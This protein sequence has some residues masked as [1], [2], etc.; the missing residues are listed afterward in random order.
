MVMPSR[1]TL[2][3]RRR[4]LEGILVVESPGDARA[5]P[6]TLEIQ[7]HRYKTLNEA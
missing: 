1:A 4:L 2:G 7:D 3:D 5:V 6:K